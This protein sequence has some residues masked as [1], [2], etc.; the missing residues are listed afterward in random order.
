MVQDETHRK[1]D[2]CSAG[3]TWKSESGRV[4]LNGEQF[5]IKGANW[6]GFETESHVLHGLWG[7]TTMERV[8]NFC[9]ANK[10][11]AL[12]VP[13]SLDLA[14]NSKTV[15]ARGSCQECSAELAWDMLDR[16]FV[17]AAARGIVIVLDM[18]RLD[19]YNNSDLWYDGK[20]T[21][22]QFIQGWGDLLTRF[23][24]KANLMGIDLK[25]EP[26]GA[27]TWG[28]GSATDWNAAAVY[29]VK[30]IKERVPGYNKLIFVEGVGTDGA[31]AQY[32]PSDPAFDKF[33]GQ[34]LD[35]VISHPIDFGTPELN[36]L[37]VYSPHVYGPSVADQ[38]Y[39]KDATF[40]ANMP[41]IWDKQVGFVED[42]TGKALVT[43]AWGG[44]YAGQDKL[45]QDAWADYMIDRCIA[46]N[47]V[48]ALNPNS[49]SN[50]GLLEADW[51]TPV[52][53]KLQLLAKIQPNPSVFTSAISSSVVCVNYGAPANSKCALKG[54]GSPAD[55]KP[56][57]KPHDAPK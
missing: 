32:P 6:F 19:Q 37:L 8:L 35:G 36:S 15:V 48:W 9:Q 49:G 56:D 18:H 39:F 24:D 51:S 38:V 44:S 11:N 2:L 50:G 1:L 28:L 29:I 33:W 13:V 22:D 53:T 43:G 45:W 23:G 12:R 26:H 54:P 17:M 3:M 31:I 55:S 25:N 40:P 34:N 16:L 41:S 27:A 47:F 20:H 52:V 21:Q 46:D 42:A 7:A 4:K 14:L 30:K 5:H 10:I 57:A